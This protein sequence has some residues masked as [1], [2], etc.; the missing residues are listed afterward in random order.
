MTAAR[1][2]YGVLARDN[3]NLGFSLGL[4]QTLDTMGYTVMDDEPYPMQLAGA[5]MTIPF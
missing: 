5:D 3:W 4:G 1:V 2:S